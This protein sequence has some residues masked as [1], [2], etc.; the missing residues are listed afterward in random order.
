MPVVPYNWE[1]VAKLTP[2]NHALPVL[3]PE[4]AIFNFDVKLGQFPYYLL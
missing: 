3:L 2:H 1:K 4:C